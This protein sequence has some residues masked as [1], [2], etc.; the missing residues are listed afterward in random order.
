ME[1]GG[2]HS[3]S[4]PSK[5]LYTVGGVRSAVRGPPIVYVIENREIVLL[6]GLLFLY[7]RYSYFLPLL[8]SSK[9]LAGPLSQ[10]ARFISTL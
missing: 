3:L 2:S 4:S 6:F 9:Y 10:A 1:L 5:A 8:S 7:L